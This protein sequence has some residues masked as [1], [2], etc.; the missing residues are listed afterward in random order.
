MARCWSAYVP[1]NKL[2]KWGAGEPSW[3]EISQYRRD[4]KACVVQWE[5][6]L[7]EN[8][9]L[10][11]VWYP[12]GYGAGVDPVHQIVVPRELRQRI[13]Q[14][15]H[16]SPLGG[17]LGR[18]K[19]VQRVWQRFYWVGYKEEVAE[20]CRRCDSCAM[21]KSGPHR[22]RAQMGQ[23]PVGASLE[24]IALDVMGPLPKT[25][26]GH[27]YSGGGGLFY[28]IDGSLCP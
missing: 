18:Y 16:N 21:V 25:E 14:S 15:L 13:L 24:R 9:I 1:S 5:S 6:L 19:T 17:H 11:R 23:V 26:N 20:W 12:R 8:G 28:Q 3:I 4:T 22:K 27:K 7:L 2:A 10:C